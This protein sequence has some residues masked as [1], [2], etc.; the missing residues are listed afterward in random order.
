MKNSKVDRWALSLS[1]FSIQ[2]LNSLRLSEATW[3]HRF[4]SSLGQVMACCLTA[5]SHYLTQCWQIISEVLWLFIWFSHESWDFHSCMMGKTQHKCMHILWNILCSICSRLAYH[6]LTHWP[7]GD[8]PLKSRSHPSGI[9][10]K[11]RYLEHFP[12]KFPSDEPYNTSLMISQHITLAQG[13]AW[14]HQATTSHKL[15]QCWPSSVMPYGTTRP[16]WVNNLSFGIHGWP[17]TS[18]YIPH[19]PWYPFPKPFMSS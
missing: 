6:E 17:W 7:L 13:M 8:V 14:R 5:S 16:W 12:L 15:N 3:W 1:Q 4:V 2:L 9:R 19:V 10:I 18:Y 11:Y